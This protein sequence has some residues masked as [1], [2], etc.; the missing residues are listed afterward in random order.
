MG[1][2]WRITPALHGSISTRKL[3]TPLHSNIYALRPKK[4]DQSAD[5]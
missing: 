5:R 4:D 3:Q 1:Q 2:K